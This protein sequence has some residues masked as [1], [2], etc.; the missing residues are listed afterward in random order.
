[1]FEPFEAAL[2]VGQ[3]PLEGDDHEGEPLQARRQIDL[4]RVRH[5]ARIA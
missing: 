1:M 5:A 4:E 2:E 3:I